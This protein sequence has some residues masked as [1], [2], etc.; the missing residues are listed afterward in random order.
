MNTNSLSAPRIS[1]VVC[2]YNYGHLVSQAIQSVLE[3]DV[4]PHEVIVV[5]DGSTDNSIEIIK[6]YS[7]IQLIT[8]ENEGQISAYNSGFE[9]VTGDVVL[10]LDSDDRLQPHALRRVGEV[11]GQSD[12]VRMHFQL[13]LINIS[14]EASDAVIPTDLASGDLSHSVRKGI[15][16]LAAPGSGNAY[17]VSVLKK[18]M[19]LPRTSTGKHGADFLAGYGSALLGKTVALKEVLADYRI[20]NTESMQ[21]LHFGNASLA[22]TGA[23]MIKARYENLRVWIQN[24]MPNEH[25]ARDLIVDF[26]LIKKD[27]ASAILDAPDYLSGLRKGIRLVPTLYRSI[28]YRASPWL[29]KIGL[30]SWVLFTLLAPRTFGRSVARYVCNPSSRMS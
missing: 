7:G 4:K 12:A 22:V 20:H 10:F 15:L 18:L 17:R 3:Q 21:S 5:D 1:V 24:I 23:E 13:R 29:M 26:S 9:R 14:G 27:Y 6:K 30:L 8:K 16:F 2:N 25:L 11:M 19:P 28:I